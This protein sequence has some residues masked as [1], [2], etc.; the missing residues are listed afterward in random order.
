MSSRDDAARRPDLRPRILRLLDEATWRYDEE[1]D[2][3]EIAL[4]GTE[5]RAGLAFPVEDLYVRV[6][7]DSFEPLSIIV[8][9]YTAWLAEQPPVVEAESGPETWTG[10]TYR[11]A[12][13]AIRRTVRESRELAA[14]SVWAAS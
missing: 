13:Q 8:P 14:A 6:D 4:P 9:G 10:I 2:E 1:I 12:E 3:L 5:G 11:T 7:P